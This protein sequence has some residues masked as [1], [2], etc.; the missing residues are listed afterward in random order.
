MKGLQETAN[1]L[2]LI[3]ALNW[4]LEALDYNIVEMLLKDNAMYVYY[5]VGAAAVYAL[6]MKLMK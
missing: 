3:G 5:L 6:Y 1:W 4:G 2:V